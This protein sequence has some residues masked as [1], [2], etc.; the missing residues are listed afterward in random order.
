MKIVTNP[1][2]DKAR[3][4]L[5]YLDKDGKVIRETGRTNEYPERFDVEGLNKVKW[6]P[7]FVESKEP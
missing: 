4:S 3:Y 7:Q 6:V 1:E 2:W 5:V